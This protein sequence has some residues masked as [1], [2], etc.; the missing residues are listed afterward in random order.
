M[1]ATKPCVV[2]VCCTN[3]PSCA[4]ALCDM[5]SMSSFLNTNPSPPESVSTL[6]TSPSD[7][8]EFLQST[9]RL[10]YRITIQD[11]RIFIGQFACIDKQ[12]NIVLTNADEYRMGEGPRGRYVGLI[13]VPWRWVVKAEVEQVM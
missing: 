7:A 10:Q 6:T 5:T 11:G 9:L 3:T 13:L 8:L 1:I 2:N 12:K 4:S